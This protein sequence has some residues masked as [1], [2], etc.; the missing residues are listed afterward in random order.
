[1]Q[2]VAMADSKGYYKVEEKNK[3]DPVWMRCPLCIKFKHTPNFIL[4]S[5]YQHD[6]LGVQFPANIEVL[7]ELFEEI[8]IHHGYRLHYV[9]SLP[10]EGTLAHLNFRENKID[11]QKGLHEVVNLYCIIHELAHMIFCSSFPKEDK[12]DHFY[13]IVFAYTV[14]LNM[15]IDLYP[16]LGKEMDDCYDRLVGF[17]IELDKELP[18]RRPFMMHKTAVW[19]LAEYWANSANAAIYNCMKELQEEK[20]WEDGLEQDDLYS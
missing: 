14:M 7:T 1:M 2:T 8:V 18:G 20:E 12:V 11:I 9:D 6:V 5:I 10:D 13:V 3:K 17:G 19:G 4:Y 16:W 15:G